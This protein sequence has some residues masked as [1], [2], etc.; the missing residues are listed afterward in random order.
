MVQLIKR[1]HE[2]LM[3]K[4]ELVRQRN[5]SLEK[6]AVEKESLVNE[7]KLEQDKLTQKLYLLQ[8]THE[9]VIN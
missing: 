8:R 4:Y 5:E 1:N 6:M 9:D 2:T 7:I 3:E